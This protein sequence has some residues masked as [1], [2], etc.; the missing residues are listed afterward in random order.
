MN[1]FA[2]IKLAVLCLLGFGIFAA[3]GCSGFAARSMN[4]EGVQ[5]FQQANY[6]EAL[7]QFQQAIQSDP[8]NADAY[9]NIAATYHRIGKDYNRPEDLLQ[10]ERSYNLC[11]D[12]D[13]DHRECHRALAV[14]LAEEGRPQDAV[15]LLENWS[16]RNSMSPAP[17]IELARLYN[18]MGNP[19]AANDQLV[20]SVQIDPNNAQTWAAL[21]K[22]NEE[23]GDRNQALVNY[24]RS[25]ELNG[26]Q[27]EVQARVASLQPLV[28]YTTPLPGPMPEPSTGPLPVANRDGMPRR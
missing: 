12:H 28:G 24:R 22:V 17:K 20:R 1:N 6:R 13:P 7:A 25:L 10:A 26:F 27:P 3:G 11:L 21:G 9:Y 14:L 4:A 23:M 8:S 5:Y 19:R 15:R 18:E 16:D 2:Q